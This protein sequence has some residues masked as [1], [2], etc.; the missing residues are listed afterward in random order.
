[1]TRSTVYRGMVVHKHQCNLGFYFILL[2][3]HHPQLAGSCSYD[4][5]EWVLFLVE[6]VLSSIRQRAIE[7]LSGVLNKSPCEW[8]NSE[9]RLSIAPLNLELGEVVG[10]GIHCCRLVDAKNRYPVLGGLI[11]AKSASAINPKEAKNTSQ[12]VANNRIKVI[13]GIQ[14]FILDEV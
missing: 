5:E 1:M 12:A 14:D 8:R 4:Q 11:C 7:V 3:P 10:M 2:H 6:D 9:V 13:Q